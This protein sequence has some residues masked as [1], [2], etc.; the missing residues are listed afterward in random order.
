M[1]NKLNVPPT[2]CNTSRCSTATQ[3]DDADEQDAGDDD[4]ISIESS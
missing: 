4:V 3:D 1:G 2:S